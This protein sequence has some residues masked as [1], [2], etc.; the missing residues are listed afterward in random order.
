M[1]E[2][3]PRRSFAPVLFG[4]TLTAGLLLL[5]GYVASKRRTA[6]AAGAPQLTITRPFKS[7]VVDS[8]LIVRFTSARHITLQPGGWGYERL[9][10]HAQV[11]GVQ[12]MPAAAD[13]RPLN[14]VTFDWTL[15]AVRKGSVQLSLG[16]A[17]RNH[18]ELSH[19]GS[20]TIFFILN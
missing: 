8:P 19:G 15:P 13:I 7:D 11:N 10:V 9:H 2:R 3:L 20:D 17:D 12:H 1:N 16:W 6:D 18:R 5:I 4:I 14:R